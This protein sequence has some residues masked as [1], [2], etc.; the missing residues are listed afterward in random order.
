MWHPTTATLFN[1]YTESRSPL[2]LEK[3]LFYN[4]YL[5]RFTKHTVC[6]EKKVHLHVFTI[7]FNIFYVQNNAK[8][9]I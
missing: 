8:L 3:S 6:D 9:C 4:G 7:Y 1:C 5:L 2:Y